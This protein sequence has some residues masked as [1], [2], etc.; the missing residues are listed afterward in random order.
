MN[1]DLSAVW[2]YVKHK[3]ME[4]VFKVFKEKIAAEEKVLGLIVVEVMKRKENAWQTDR[5]R[6]VVIQKKE[7]YVRSLQKNVPEQIKYKEVV[8]VQ[9]VM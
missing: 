8:N 1:Y 9:S 7:T 4:E 5:V 2:V 6:E 3:K